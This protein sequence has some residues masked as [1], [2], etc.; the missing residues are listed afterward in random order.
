IL[1]YDNNLP[2]PEAADGSGST[3]S[4]QNPELDNSIPESWATS[5]M[6]GTPGEKNDYIVSVEETNLPAELSLAQNYP[7]PFNQV[8][9]IPFYVPEAGKVTVEVY[10]VLG[11]RVAKILDG[12]MPAGQHT[13]VF[14]ADELA[15]GIYF[16]TVKASGMMKTK[17]MMFLK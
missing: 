15:A 11:Q 2:W 6:H 10:S 3:L 13:V 12:N 4:L 16:Y 14:Q 9:V 1:T 17:Q 7:N 5:V 8:T